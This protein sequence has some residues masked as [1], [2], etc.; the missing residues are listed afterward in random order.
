MR[1]VAALLLGGLISCC[2]GLGTASAQSTATAL[3][4]ESP[5]LLFAAGV[6]ALTVYMILGA[7]LDAGLPLV[8]RSATL[9]LLS[10]TGLTW[11]PSTDHDLGRS[12]TCLRATL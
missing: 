7:L 9:G 11:E 12:V 4:V 8:L 6:F 5:S 1:P 3:S 2:D 10:A